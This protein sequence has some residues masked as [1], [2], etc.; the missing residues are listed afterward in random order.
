ML[1]TTKNVI[2]LMLVAML[3]M[4]MGGGCPQTTPPPP[5]A[6]ATT[7]VSTTSVTPPF[8]QFS[9]TVVGKT[10]TVQVSGNA[11]GSRITVLTNDANGIP[12]VNI[13]TPTSSTSSASFTSQSTGLHFMFT[14]EIGAPSSVYTVLI[15]QSP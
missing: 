10:I 2:G 4:V 7:L 6:G 1:N 15:T 9:P 8:A 13:L 11:T 3:P 14:A 5:P 12:V